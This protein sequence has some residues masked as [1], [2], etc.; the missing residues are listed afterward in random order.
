[1][2]LSDLIREP[3]VAPDGPPV[4]RMS[5][6]QALNALRRGEHVEPDEPPG[7]IGGL[8]MPGPMP[9]AAPPQRHDPLADITAEQ[10]R[11]DEQDW[12]E[13]LVRVR[14]KRIENSQAAPSSERDAIEQ[15]L[16]EAERQLREGY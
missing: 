11:Q 14:A 1:M 8:L 7:G 6:V 9:L 13:M 4:K 2:G 3:D 5:L 12:Q 10:A 15:R 16:S